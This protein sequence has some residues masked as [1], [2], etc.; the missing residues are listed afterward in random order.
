MA[1]LQSFLKLV[2]SKNI[3]IRLI[4]S[5]ALSISLATFI[6]RNTLLTSG[7]P[8]FGDFVFNL[9]P[10]WISSRFLT[11]WNPYLSADTGADIGLYPWFFWLLFLGTTEFAVKTLLIANI[12]YVSFVA[13]QVVFSFVS[14]RISTSLDRYLISSLVAV[15]SVMNP[16]IVTRFSHYPYFWLIGSAFFVFYLIDKAMHQN[17]TKSLLKYSLISSIPFLIAS[18]FI[19]NLMLL[20]FFT[21]C[22]LFLELCFGELDFKKKLKNATTFATVLILTLGALFAFMF[23]PLI[24]TGSASAYGSGAPWI[25]FLTIGEL[26]PIWRNSNVVNSFWLSNYW[27]IGIELYNEAGLIQKLWF[28]LTL[29]LPTLALSSVLFR[30]RDRT[31]QLLLVTVIIFIGLTSAPFGPF[32]DVYIAV[33]DNR[34]LHSLMRSPDKFT[35]FLIVA[36]AILSG[37]TLSGIF[38]KINK[39][40][41]GMGYKHVLRGSIVALM[42]ATIS[43]SAYPAFSG[44][45]QGQFQPIQFPS[46]YTDAREWLKTQEGEFRVFWFPT[47]AVVSWAPKGGLLPDLRK[48]ISPNPV[49]M[50]AGET[51]DKVLE[52]FIVHSL[53]YAGA[54]SLGRVLIQS[55]IRFLVY[56]D[57]I[58]ENE[59]PMYKNVLQ[60]LFK[61]QD[62]SLVF[63]SEDIYIFENQEW[64][65][66]I[67]SAVNKSV[68]IV[69]GMDALG[70]LLEEDLFNPSNSAVVF[71]EQKPYSLEDLRSLAQFDSVFYFFNRDVDD[72][73]LSVISNK[74][75]L[76]PYS[77]LKFSETE[78]RGDLSSVSW[79]GIYGVSGIV[80]IPEKATSGRFD[81]DYGKG[82]IWTNKPEAKFDFSFEIEENDTYEIWTRAF[83]SHGGGQIALQIDDNNLDQLTLANRSVG[84]RWLK[85]GNLDLEKGHHSFSITNVHGT[86]IFNLVALVPSSYRK[87]C[88]NEVQSL[89]Q[90][91]NIGI[92]YDRHL[93]LENVALEFDDISSWDSESGEWRG[94][95]LSIISNASRWDVQDGML[96]SDG[97]PFY[98]LIKPKNLTI[99]NG[100]VEASVMVPAPNTAAYLAFRVK[101]ITNL[102]IFGIVPW[103]N[104]LDV[105]KFVNGV[106]TRMLHLEYTIEPYQWYRLKVDFTGNSLRGSIDDHAVFELVDDTF[107]SGSA[108]LWV[109]GRNGFFDAM[110][111]WNYGGIGLYSAKPDQ[112]NPS[113]ILATQ[114]TTFVKKVERISATDL[115]VGIN[116]SGPFILKLSEKYHAQW[117]A[118][119]EGSR[120][121]K[122]IIF[123]AYN[124]FVS[125]KLGNYTITIK[126]APQEYFNYGLAISS[127]TLIAV[128]IFMVFLNQTGRSAQSQVAQETESEVSLMKS[129]PKLCALFLLHFLEIAA[130]LMIV[131]QNLANEVATSAYF[132]LI[133]AL[134]GLL[135]ERPL[136]RLRNEHISSRRQPDIS[137][138]L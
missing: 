55:N 118:V 10:K 117:D 91:D 76:A 30:S 80:G 79:F 63:G 40:R 24:M 1:R 130:I 49:F 77:L 104:S 48:W 32:R 64:K 62:L 20:L 73:V 89:L 25:R 5:L 45:I 84:F 128:L 136:L 17:S 94:D 34:F 124:G 41:F 28:V 114:E 87:Q 29:A 121:N 22:L 57:D 27:A 101:D 137:Q 125:S 78:W 60:N 92:L 86:N 66:E 75:H 35:P 72:L 95:G 37:I 31:V 105:S 67:V 44:D 74:Y 51:Y 36:Y 103:Q 46:S 96:H 115:S 98:R 58:M 112:P 39:L 102:Y 111:A 53:K 6:F 88:A 13:F 108:G 120:M 43:I 134:A 135:L 127:L 133:L 107:E 23:L 2:P 59:K 106:Q 116:A 90:R 82:F 11:T 56:H 138:D 113:V 7:V 123:S 93:W 69:G 16:W 21:A 54:S 109:Y 110:R 38:A 81:F 3:Q 33:M 9:D 18:G 97:P 26:N 50:P 12:V 99:S 61:Q 4:V 52:N 100:A 131:D 65:N 68:I 132:L 42:I 71:I 126:F 122:T 70:P 129:F 83:V 85:A 14:G 15:F 119:A 19:Y 8:E 47:E